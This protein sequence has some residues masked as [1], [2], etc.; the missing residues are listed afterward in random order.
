[1]SIDKCAAQIDTPLADAL[2]EASRANR[3][4]AKLYS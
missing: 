3:R 4:R 1:M 2:A